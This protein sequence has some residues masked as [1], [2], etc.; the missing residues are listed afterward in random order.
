MTRRERY[1]LWRYLVVGFVLL[2]GAGAA[3]AGTAGSTTALR[4]RPARPTHQVIQGQLALID[5]SVATLWTRPDHTR[6]L[7]APSLSNPVR[8]SAWLDAMDLEQ[9]RWLVGRLVDQALYG[10]EVAVRAQRGAWD[11]VALTGQATA[12]GV[13]YPGWL[14]ARQLVIEPSAPPQPAPTTTQTTPTSTTAAAVALV[15]QPTA[16]LR[17]LTG[18]GAAGPRLLRLSFNTRLP[19]LGQSGPWAIV[20]TPTGT[21]ALIAQS[22]VSVGLLDGLQPPPTASQ[23]VHTAEQFL[24]LRYLYAGTSGFGFDC[25]GFTYTIYGSHGIVLPRNSAQQARVGQPVARGALRPG[26]LVFFATDPPSR[27]ISHVAMYI[28]NGNIIESPNSASAVRIIPLADR[29]AEY[30]TARRYLPAS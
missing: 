25:S 6:P 4:A 22:D 26:D 18:S 8:L 2:A 20:Q 19:Y 30:V 24:G 23:L 27:A 14:P 1:R 3:P 7:D 9:R 13:G 28:G 29:A 15:T 21:S 17:G 16:W 12:T 10:Q 11:E 5:V